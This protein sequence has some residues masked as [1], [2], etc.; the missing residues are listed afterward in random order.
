MESYDK[1]EFTQAKKY[2]K[3]ACDLQ[4]AEGCT[5]LGIS[6]YN[7]EGV[8]GGLIKAIQY[9]KKAC[10]LNNGFGCRGLSFLYEN[11]Y[12]VEEDQEKAAQYYEKRGV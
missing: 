1:Q 11:G 6:Y 10:D 8:K 7:G 12:G 4:Y 3:K 9:Y 2:F 5:R